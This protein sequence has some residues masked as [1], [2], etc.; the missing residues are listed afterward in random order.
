VTRDSEPTPALLAGRRALDDIPGYTLLADWSW[1]P[2]VYKWVLLCRLTINVSDTSLIPPIS[3]WYVL[4]DSSYPW[5]KIKFYP[6]KSGGIDK[7]FQHQSYNGFGEDNI[8]WRT[9][10][11][12]VDTQVQVLGRHAANAEPFDVDQ[13]LR[14]RVC[15]AITWLETASQ[16]KLALA[17]EPFELPWFPTCQKAPAKVAFWEDESTFAHWET[18]ENKFGT[19]D[20]IM[21]NFSHIVVKQ[22][23]SLDGKVLLEPKWGDAIPKPD[24]NTVN[25][26]WIRLDAPP[27]LLPWQVPTAWGDLQPIL[28]TNRLTFNDLP[29]KMTSA[30]RDGQRHIALLGYPIPRNTGEPPCRMQWAAIWLPHFSYG[31]QMLDGFRPNETGYRQRDKAKVFYNS[32]KI[33][34]LDT[35]NWSAEQITSRGKL[36]DTLAKQRIC[37]IGVGALGSVISEMLVRA[38]VE[39]LVIVDN[40]TVE[41]GNLVRHTTLLADLD[42]PKAQAIAQRL[43]AI[44]PHVKVTV[45]I[46]SFLK[47]SLSETECVK[48]C[49][50]IIDCTA[51]DTV[52]YHLSQFDWQSQRLFISFSLGFKARRLYCYSSY[53][54][55]FPHDSFRDLI[56]R[57]LI[58]EREEMGDFEFPQEGIGCWHPIFPARIDDVWMFAGLAIKWIEKAAKILSTQPELTI[59]EQEFQEG[60]CTGIRKCESEANRE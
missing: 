5:G 57:W 11:I 3:D 38:G 14:W 55:V 21:T 47:L 28:Q 12:C 18:I 9:G 34:W 31:R 36:P 44:S 26:I 4:V 51:D 49:G 19:I 43:R 24:K 29:T 15:R 35:A 59:F 37:I 48:Q 20:F 16:N 50:V 60:I 41:I 7:T 52:I 6:A 42:Q 27:V 10:D 23:C 54:T 17:G 45:I 53:S 8:P 39:E 1:N 46:N 22:F 58:K 32:A 40:D 30:L 33:D 13:R 25:G 2:L 56:G